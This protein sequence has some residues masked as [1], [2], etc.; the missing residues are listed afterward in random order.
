MTH[1]EIKAELIRMR[2]YFIHH[3]IQAGE[4]V[5]WTRL[6][7]AFGVGEVTA[8]DAEWLRKFEDGQVAEGNEHDKE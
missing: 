3:D 1:S 8:I 7:A 4:C 5:G 2:Q 6:K